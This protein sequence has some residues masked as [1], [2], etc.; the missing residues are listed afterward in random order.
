MSPLQYVYLNMRICNVLLPSSRELELEMLE[1][2]QEDLIVDA[3]YNEDDDQALY[4][5]RAPG[6]VVPANVSSQRKPSRDPLLDDLNRKRP[7][8]SDWRNLGWGGENDEGSVAGAVSTDSFAEATVKDCAVATWDPTRLPHLNYGQ[9]WASMLELA[10]NWTSTAAHPAEYAAF[11]MELYVEVFGHNFDEE[12][13][14]LA[15]ALQASAAQLA[16]ETT[17]EEE[18]EKAIREFHELMDNVIEEYS[19][20][21]SERGLE[22]S[23]DAFFSP[24]LS[25]D[26]L[27]SLPS[28]YSS[29]SS[30]DSVFSLLDATEGGVGVL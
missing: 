26:D 21:A 25:D 28:H 7:S 13:P 16:A 11:L 18:V 17:C 24:P 9:F 5:G 19:E 14:A 29:C 1:S 10:D 15:E 3:T 6:F 8:G 23:R 12:D 2:I 4:F 30:M 27:D 20:S 22:D